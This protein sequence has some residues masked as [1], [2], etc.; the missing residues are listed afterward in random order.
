MVSLF[1]A[2]ILVASLS[3]LDAPPVTNQLAQCAP[4]A[5]MLYHLAK[6]F[7]ERPAWQGSL[8]NGVRI[9]IAISKRGNW[10]LLITPPAKNSCIMAS[11]HDW[12][13]ASAADPVGE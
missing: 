12:L 5:A 13:P 7:D 4:R 10:T 2:S 3:P 11:G 1:G 9:E 6:N 8:P